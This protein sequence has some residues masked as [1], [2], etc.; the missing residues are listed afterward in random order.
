QIPLQAREYAPFE[1]VKKKVVMTWEQTIDYLIG[2]RQNFVLGSLCISSSRS[3]RY[4]MAQKRYSN[5]PAKGAEFSPKMLAIADNIL[6]FGEYPQLV[7]SHFLDNG[8]EA[9]HDRLEGKKP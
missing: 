6:E 7:F 1:I 9:A 8:I 3:S 4:H 5:I 2:I